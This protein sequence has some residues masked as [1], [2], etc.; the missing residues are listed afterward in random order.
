M[1]KLLL[2]DKKAGFLKEIGFIIFQGDEIILYIENENE[3]RGNALQSCIQGLK[4]SSHLL[5]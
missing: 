2:F 4:N 3:S 1:I 5:L